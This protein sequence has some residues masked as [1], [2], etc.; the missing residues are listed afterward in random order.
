MAHVPVLLNE[1][2][3][4]L[5]PKPNQNF[6]DATVGDGGHAK[7]ILEKTS[8]NGKLIA[9]DRDIDSI[10]RAKSNLK[11]FG[12]RVYFINDSFGNILRIVEENG[13]GSANGIIFD[14]GMSTNQLENSGRGFSFQ[15]DEIL[16]MR[17]DPKNPL[18]AEVLV[19]D[20]SEA[21]LIAL[22]NKFGEE[23]KAKIIARAIVASRRNQKI[24]TTKDLVE[25]IERVV[26]RHGKLNPATLVFQAIRI[27]VNQELAEI[28]KALAGVPEILS[29]GGRAA[30]ISFHSLEDRLIKNWSRDLNKKN[31]VKI[32][33][34]KP[35]TASIEE[36]KI[37][38]KSRSAKL[39]IIEKA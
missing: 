22:F 35:I 38:P 31:I 8:P 21:Q 33:N 36:I 6:I 3:D 29:S 13:F 12:N 17:F 26:K 32:L 28:G 18:T 1:V 24:K 7:A 11:E 2:M 16:D 15:K 10:I 20:Y 39:R 27:E 30:F 23:P 25:I 5:A 14:F 37:N 34:K 4:F 19:N 9:I